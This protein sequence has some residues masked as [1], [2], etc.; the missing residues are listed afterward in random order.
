ME[1]SVLR[2]LRREFIF[3]DLDFTQ[4][5]ILS[6][7]FERLELS[8]GE[9]IALRGNPV[10]AF[11]LVMDG[12]LNLVTYRR[13]RQINLGA[14][15]TGDF[16]GETGLLLRHS[17][18]IITIAQTPAVLLRLPREVCL[19]WLE[20]VPLLKQKL[21]MVAM[22]RALIPRLGL[23][24]LEAEETVYS[25]TRKHPIFLWMGMFLPLLFFI[26]GSTIMV[27]Q[28]FGDMITS[29]VMGGVF[30]CLSFGLAW[31]R[32]VDWS[33]DYYV[34]TSTRVLWHEKI[35]GIYDSQL[36]A[37]LNTIMAVNITTSLWG[38][39][40]GYG[41]VE[42]RTLTGGIMMKRAN[43]AK[44]FAN[45]IEGYR[46]RV[47]Y[48]SREQELESIRRDIRHIIR[49]E[50]LS[51]E[52]S[53]EELPANE[54][55]AAEKRV[56]SVVGGARSRGW[57][58]TFLRLRYEKDGI[59]TYRKHWLILLK[60]V[61]RPLVLFLGSFVLL[62]WVMWQRAINPLV[63][64]IAFFFMVGFFLWLA[65]EY[66]DWSNDIYQLTPTQILDI[67]KK[68]LGREQKKTAPLD[69]PD[70]RIEHER[71]NL[72]AI[73]FDF[74]NVIVNVGQTPFIFYGVRKPDMVHHDIAEYRAALLERKQRQEREREAEK[75]RDWFSAYYRASIHE[76]SE[77][78]EGYEDRG[79]LE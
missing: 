49:Q 4:L 44:M 34:L 11:Y 17:F 62:V 7:E 10:D 60:K 20:N 39:L 26:L 56:A 18:P 29:A 45:F 58:K 69:A 70:I 8:K 42:V 15:N 19:R 21:F 37:P 54:K 67:E 55:P 2:I 28:L 1:S 36:D 57:W 77:E 43:S 41:N 22:S 6:E 61:W 31:W 59:I 75:M 12:T 5:K 79:F 50:D 3:A 9:T 24:W 73:L 64:G 14:L 30:L 51:S 35:F 48:I 68:P 65:Y 40:I 16:F 46:T 72:I 25:L 38:R 33:N 76:G 52:L 66:L 23:N 63:I 27:F 13:D 78:E 32:W 53:E 74:G 71:K 47:R